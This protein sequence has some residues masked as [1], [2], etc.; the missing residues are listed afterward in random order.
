MRRVPVVNGHQ[1]VVG[2]VSLGDLVRYGALSEPD[3]HE[4]LCRIYE[5]LGVLGQ[6]MALGKSA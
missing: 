6:E 2:M 4:A 1:A 5:P 3:L